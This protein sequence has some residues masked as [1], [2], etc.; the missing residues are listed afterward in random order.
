MDNTLFT[1]ISSAITGI[2]TFFLGAKKQKLENESSSLTNIEHS[3]S[4]YKIIIDD[5][6]TQIKEL[7]V[8][9]NELEAKVDSLTQENHELKDMLRQ[10]N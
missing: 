8:K 6:K 2:V 10:R 7:L 5:L 1:V 4:V 3:I 9:V